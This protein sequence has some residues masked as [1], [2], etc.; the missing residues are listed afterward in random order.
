M[1]TCLSALNRLE[2]IYI[3][4]ESP[5]SLPGRKTQCPQPT[6]TPLP[7]LTELQF[8]GVVEYLEEL[9]PRIDAPV[10]DTLTIIFF[11]RLILETPQLTQFISRTPKFKALDEARVIFSVDLGVLITLPR[12]FGGALRLG[13]SCSQPDWQL[14]SLAQLCSLSFPQALIHGVQHFYI[15]WV[16]GAGLHPQ[17]DMESSQWVEVFHPFVAVKDLYIPQEF[18]PHIASVLQELVGEGATEVLPT[19][20]T[21]FLEEPLP[22]GAVEEATGPF[23]AARQLSSHPVAVSRWERKMNKWDEFDHLL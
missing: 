5:R 14:S 8:R 13:V 19:L 10:L 18:T 2:S 23:I 15:L 4:F 11:H 3:G 9:V 7:A 20:K 22:T 17:D 1:V 6:R 16:F 21:L 12:T